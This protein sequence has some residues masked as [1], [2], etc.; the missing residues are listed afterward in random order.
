MQKCLQ[1]L[2]QG[3]NVSLQIRPISV[4]P[5]ISKLIENHISRH[6]YQYLAKYNLLH[7]AQS[8]FRSNH[9][10]QSALI[11]I[12]DKWIE[13][14]NNGN[15][16]VVILL[17]LKK[18]FDV[19]DHDIMAKKL[20]I[21]GFN[22]KALALFNSYMTNYVKNYLVSKLTQ[23]LIGKTK[24]ITSVLKYHQQSTFFQKLRNI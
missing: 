10:C 21:Y 17:D 18:A 22:K 7:D 3:E 6:M 2:I 13:E 1:I 12:I 4:L 19:V 20:E 24:L 11:N 16:N 15:V 23:I 5:V 8:G 9:S 14:M